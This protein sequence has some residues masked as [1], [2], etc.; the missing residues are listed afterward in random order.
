VLKVESA[1]SSTKI[2][3]ALINIEVMVQNRIM[4][5]VQKGCPLNNGVDTAKTGAITGP[6]F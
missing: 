6:F 1:E 3:V 5:Y 2:G 4:K